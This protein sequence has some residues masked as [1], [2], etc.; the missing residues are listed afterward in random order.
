[1][2]PVNKK[3]MVARSHAD[4]LQVTCAACWQK[5]GSVRKV[6]DNISEL[7]KEHVCGDYDRDIVY[8]M[9]LIGLLWRL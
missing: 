9:H 1:M 3:N 6:S 7:I 2:P 8:T 4:S 5:K